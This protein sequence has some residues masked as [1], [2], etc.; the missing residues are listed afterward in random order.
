MDGAGLC[1]IIG[2]FLGFL[3]VAQSACVEFGLSRVM[4]DLDIELTG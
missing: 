4:G 2:Q 3:A 1:G